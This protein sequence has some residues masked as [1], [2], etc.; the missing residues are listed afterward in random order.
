MGVDFGYIEEYNPQRG[1]GFVGSTFQN[2]EIFEK[3]TF[4]H[5]TKIKRKYPDLA[6]NLDNGICENICFWYETDKKDNK[7][8]LC[9]IWLNTN[10]VPTEY[11]ENITTKIEELWLKINKNSPHWLEKITIDLLGLDRTEEL[12]QTRENLKLQKEEA[13][14][15]NNLSPR[16]LRAEFIRKINQRSLKDI[17]LGL[18]IHLVDKVLWVSLEKRKNPLSHIPGG[19]DVVVEYH[20]GC[21]FGYNR[22]KLPSS[23][24]YTI[25]YNQME[26]DF[27]YLAEQSQI[28][29]VKDRVSKIFAR[30]YDNQDERYHI[31]FEEVWNSET[32][33]NLPWQ[34]FKH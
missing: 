18:P 13:E 11:K 28:A 26:D 8:Q 3:G 34:C 7:D 4:F 29:I 22:I 2:K 5:I 9:N 32:S 10:D 21:A 20:N 19:S 16:E 15:K 6:Q 33:N 27:D 30:E 24:I 14:Q 12:K 23:Y 1:F 17:Y 25:L 31:P